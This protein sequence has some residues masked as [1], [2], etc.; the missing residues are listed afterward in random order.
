MRICRRFAGCIEELGE[1]EINVWFDKEHLRPGA[2]KPQLR[3]AI[4]R[5]RFFLICLSE[6]A[7]KKTGDVPGFQDQELQWAYEIAA[8][9]DPAAF[10]IIPVRL[11]DCGRGDHRT[12]QW[13]QV[14]LFP[15]RDGGLKRLNDW[16]GGTCEEVSAGEP[17]SEQSEHEQLVDGLLGKAAVFYYADDY[18]KALKTLEAI[19][20]IEERALL[21]WAKQGCRAHSD[22]PVRG[23]S[24]S[25]GA[26][27]RARF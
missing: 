18:P 13:Q 22:G 24:G 1:C 19:T 6:A 25:L 26:R 3:R 8:N 9:Q 23:G 12:S 20:T 21:A 27:H 5:S 7:L 4:T 15:E 11:E 14:D 17:L 10:T 16:L 2:W